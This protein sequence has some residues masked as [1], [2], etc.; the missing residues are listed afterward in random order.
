MDAVQVDRICLMN[1]RVLYVGRLPDLADHRQAAGLLCVGLERP[2][3]VLANG[4]V[5]VTRSAVVLPQVMHALE[6]DGGLCAFLL[7]D[8]DHRDFD[9]LRA[10][11]AR[12]SEEG[13]A[14][15]LRDENELMQK[16]Q[17]V[18]DHSGTDLPAEVWQNLVLGSSS[19]HGFDHRLRIVIEELLRNSLESIPVERLAELAGI[20]P[21]RLAHLFKEHVGIPI[22]KFRAWARLKTA[23]LLLKEGANLT[24]AAHG[25]GFYDSAHFTNTFRENFGLPPSAVFSPNRRLIWHI[26][27]AQ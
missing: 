3:R 12:S 17:P 4:K 1:G 6:L 2:F 23:A 20:S 22:R 25:A 14:T 10:Y 27:P 18:A 11:E 16:I 24:E 21:S 13:I 7:V 19:G 8:P 5:H 9:L 26:H 15:D